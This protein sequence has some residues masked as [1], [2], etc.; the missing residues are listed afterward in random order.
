MSVMTKNLRQVRDS[1]R[2]KVNLAL[3]VKY[4]Y[5][6]AMFEL[7][8]AQRIAERADDKELLDA[9]NE[10]K[11]AIIR[12]VNRAEELSIQLSKLDKE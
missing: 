1:L 6:A 3:C 5:A 10:A 4:Q 9:C 2:E 12:A 7:E 8:A 11:Y